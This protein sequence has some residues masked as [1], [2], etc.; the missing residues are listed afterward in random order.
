MP[1]NPRKAK[2]NSNAD[3]AYRKARSKVRQLIGLYIHATVFVVVN[4]ILATVN[5]LVTPAFL[6]FLFPLLGWGIGLFI[7]ILVLYMP[8]LPFFGKEWRER[9]IQEILAKE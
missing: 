8:P 9:K 1:R 7:H 2:S 3:A 4:A 5:L 6:W